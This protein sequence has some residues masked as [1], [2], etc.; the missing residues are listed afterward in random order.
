MPWRDTEVFLNNP[1]P[2]G[3][4]DYRN[5]MNIKSLESSAAQL[6]NEY[7]W[8]WL[9][10]DGR[11]S[12]LTIDF[13]KYYLG[14]KLSTE[15]NRR[16]Q[17]YWLQLETE[18]LRSIREHAGVLAFTHLTNNYGYTGDWFIDDI[19]DLE[20]S[21]VLKWFK[22]AF[23]PAAVFINLTDE[24]YVKFTEAHK[25]GSNLVFSLVGINDSEQAVNG[26]LQLVLYDDKGV[27]I[28]Y[29]GQPVELSPTIRT[30]IPMSIKLPEKA[31]G[32]LLL[33]TFIPDDQ[34]GIKR[35]SRRYI[36]IGKLENYK[37]WDI[38]L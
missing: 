11:P 14:E 17:A 13:Y 18:W 22:H 1:Y 37:F 12:K 35:I 2:L 10:R 15:S 4:L 31:G 36:R 32:Y 28:P 30:I 16:F 19:K 25:P 7:G 3:N 6:V 21:P 23:S 27:E 29:D 26:H 20:P 33:A 34:S 5:A 8:V 38:K 24:R 9:W